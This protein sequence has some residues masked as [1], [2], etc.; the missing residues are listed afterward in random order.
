[1]H[2]VGALFPIQ[3]EI[4]RKVYRR[5]G[6]E[7]VLAV[8]DL[9]FTIERDETLCMIGPSGAGKTTALRIL[10][11]LDWDFEGRIRPDPRSLRIGTVFQEP[12]LLPWRSVEDNVRLAL[13]RPERGRALD[14]L[15]AGLG[16]SEWR[17][18]YPA[19]LSG[20]MQRRVALARALAVEPHL[21]VLDEP[22]VSLDDHAA[23]ALREVVFGVVTQRRLSVLMVT[24]NIREAL[25][26]ADRLLLISPRPASVL[27]TIDLPV[28]RSERS[29][30]WLETRRA[31]LAAR[32]PE[33]VA[34]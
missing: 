15:F 2:G 1:M 3:L 30:A 28:P 9:S 16:L 32:Y 21:L 25:G 4:A 31:E 34:A 14:D 10:I 29:A 27:S 12:R 20:G 18:R 26:L 13:P 11:G 23:A 7:P 6:G 19:E 8:R 5:P 33:T 24:H 17:P 22:F